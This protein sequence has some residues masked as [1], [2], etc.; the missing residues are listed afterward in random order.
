LAVVV[1][2]TGL[3]AGYSYSRPKVY[4]TTAQVLVR[5]ILIQPDDQDPSDNFSMDTEALL[6]KSTPVARIAQKSMASEAGIP[7]LTKR[8]SV[9]TPEN[10]QVLQITFTDA[11]AEGARAGAQA[12]AQAYLEFK[13]QQAEDAI[14]DDTAAIDALITDIEVEIQN[15]DAEIASLTTDSP[16]WQIA[17]SDRR[18]A[19]AR[20][21]GL[22]TQIETIARSSRNPGEIVQRAERPTFPISPKHQVDLALAP[23]ARV[24]GGGRRHHELHAQ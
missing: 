10:T 21:Q 2:V 17:K 13:A 24:R 18:S 23:V 16:A 6:V 20:R 15:L 12:F 5:P 8:L 7:D 3:A 11:S 22:I 9:A 19:E 14:A 4:S 1:L